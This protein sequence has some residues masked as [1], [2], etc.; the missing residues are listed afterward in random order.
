[1]G[2]SLVVEQDPAYLRN[3]SRQLHALYRR[4]RR[5][6]NISVLIWI[7]LFAALAA[8]ALIDRIAALGW[9]YASD[10]WAFAGFAALAP[11][12]WVFA[13][14]IAKGNLAYIRHTYGPDPI[15]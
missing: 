3:Q 10:M 1:L 14:L 9:G 8:I 2:I 7:A 4:N 15:E 13:T 12:F 6:L 11:C 5:F